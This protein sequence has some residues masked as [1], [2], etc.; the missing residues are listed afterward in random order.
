VFSHPWLS[1]AVVAGLAV[2][3][4]LAAGRVRRFWRTFGQGLVVLTTPVRYLRTVAAWQALGWGCRLGAAYMFLAAFGVPATVQNAALVLVAGSLGGLFP[5]TP[6]GLGPKQALTVVV[7]AGEAGRSVVLA[8]SA[9][10]EI[11]ITVVNVLLGLT[12]IALIMRSLRLR[13]IIGRARA[14]GRSDPPG[15]GG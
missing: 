15:A 6:G 1:L 4:V 5:A 9:G 3:F 7:L 14:E 12:C 8:F 11:T 2:L 10:M 13:D